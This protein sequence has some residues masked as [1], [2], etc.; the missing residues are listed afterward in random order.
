MTS[1]GPEEPVALHPDTPTEVITVSIVEDHEGTAEL[2]ETLLDGTD[3]I[4][5]ESK[6]LRANRLMNHLG[7]LA[8]DGADLPDVVLMDIEMPGMNGIDAAAYLREHYPSVKVLIVTAFRSRPD[9]LASIDAG[10][11]GF[12]T[13]GGGA[14][15]LRFAIR[16][17]AA[18]RTYF[19]QTPTEIMAEGFKATQI[20][21]KDDPAFWQAV[22]KLTPAERKVLRLLARGM[23]NPSIAKELR[24]GL[25]TVKEQV[26][27][28]M[29]AL[30]CANRTEVALRAAENQF[31]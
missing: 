19:G 10:V 2:M 22:E 17:V 25:N 18:G 26:S 14:D 12:L 11:K 7:R 1:K 16:H 6:H 13:K 30:G 24:K 8:G 23:S 27:T 21:H 5:V 29:A 4:R 28:I 31:H 20:T 15:E 9:L 3:G